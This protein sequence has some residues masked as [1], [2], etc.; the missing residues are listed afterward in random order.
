M[1]IDNAVLKKLDIDCF[2]RIGN[3]PI[4]IATNGGLIPKKLNQEE[5]LIEYAEWVSTLPDINNSKQH[6]NINWKYVH[7][8]LAEQ[9]L[10]ARKSYLYSFRRMA[11]KGFYAYDRDILSQNREVYKLVAWPNIKLPSNLFEEKLMPIEVS[12]CEI[13]NGIL[14][15]FCLMKCD[16]VFRN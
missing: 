6:V 11:R 16:I 14:T 13:N 12:Q 10:P 5:T 2:F 7:E 8:R 3:I 15:A 9:D 1:S 4:F